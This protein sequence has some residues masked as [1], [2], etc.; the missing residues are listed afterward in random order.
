MVYETINFMQRTYIGD[1]KK[2][3]DETITIMGWVSVRRDQGKMVFFDVRDMTGTV[4]AVALPKSAAIE[5]AKE[6]N[7][8]FVVAMTG[9][10]NNRPEK[11][12]D[13]GKA[14]GDIELCLDTIEILNTSLALPFE[15]VDD[16]LAVNEDVRLK[17]RYL[18]LRSPRMQRNIRMRDKI[19]TF[20]REHMH[21]N[22]FVEVET[23][24]MMKGTPEGSREY[25]IPSRLE[26]GKFYVLPQSPQQFK[27]LLMVAG[28]ERYFQI[29]RCMRDEDT[30]GDRQPE[31]TQ[32]DFEMSFV[33]QEDVLAYTEKM[34]IELIA[35]LYPHK[36]I[37]QTPFP[38]LTFAE[39]VK[40]HGNDKPDLRK[41]KNDK[42]ELAF[43]WITEFPMFEKNDE[44]KLQAA[45]HPFCS[46][47]P[48]D[49]GKFMSGTDL[50]SI[51]A[52]SYDLVLNG[53]ELSSGS[54][55]IHNAAEQKQVFD[56]LGITEEE[57]Q[58]K[59]G[60]MLEAF[61]FGTPPHGGFAPGVDR[62]VMILEN[63]PNIRE[64]IAFAKTGEGKDLLMGAPTEV[65]KKQLDEL[66]IE[67]KKVKK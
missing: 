42:D 6:A 27:Q 65:S 2:H 37:T 38:R 56:L 22:G 50:M 63:Q 18:D 67:I 59:F 49:R 24:I 62:I 41:D 35:A 61:K 31:F 12:I 30:R 16:T 44:G 15:V 3:V 51:R 36:H 11:N 39:S 29:A 66:G 48:E 52:N 17:Y 34:F 43:A 57:Q 1:L 8:E 23:P 14:N 46:V 64:V 28:F 55:R 25:I 20:F 21:K 19:I 58:K 13:E 5:A 45:H 33:T 7:R 40:Q 4:Q 26:K 53:Y 54:I 60:H 47:H 32:L 9:M 10:V